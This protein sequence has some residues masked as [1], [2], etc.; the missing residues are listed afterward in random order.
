MFILILQLIAT[1]LSISVFPAIKGDC[2][3][4]SGSCLPSSTAPCY[5][6]SNVTKHFN[7]CIEVCNMLIFLNGTYFLNGTLLAS[8]HNSISIIGTSPHATSVVCLDSPSLFIA[9]NVTLLKIMNISWINCG[10]VYMTTPRSYTTILLQNVMSA[11]FSHVVF[12]NTQ[13]YA[14]FGVD[15]HIQLSLRNVIINHIS[16]RYTDG[17]KGIMLLNI[18]TSTSKVNHYQ[19]QKCF[20]LIINNCKFYNLYSNVN[21]TGIYVKDSSSLYHDAAAIGLI[22]HQ[23]TVVN[24]S[25]I[26]F[27]NIV[28]INTPVVSVSYLL[29]KPTF[30][31]IVNSLF[32][33]I[34]CIENSVVE[35][36]ISAK[37]QNLS[38]LH[39]FLFQD[40]T[41][42]HNNAISTDTAINTAAP[43]KVMIQFLRLLFVANTAIGTI[44]I[45]NT[46]RN[47]LNISVLIED[48]GFL[49]NDASD[50]RF[51]DIQLLTLKGRNTF[52]GN[53]AEVL[54]YLSYFASSIIQGS[55]TFSNN[56]VNVLFYLINKYLILD[57]NSLL[58]ITNNQI[59]IMND[60][61]H[62]SFYLIYIIPHVLSPDIC[63]FQILTCIENVTSLNTSIIFQN[64][65]GYR[66][67]IYGYPF[68]SCKWDYYCNHTNNILL[69][70]I[71]EIIIHDD[72]NN[73]NNTRRGDG[74]CYCET[75]MDLFTNCSKTKIDYAIYP[76]QTIR[77]PL[78]SITFNLPV[79]ITSYDKEGMSVCENVSYNICFPSPQLQIVYQTCT[80]LTYTIK[81]NSTDWCILCFKTIT[82]N[83]LQ[84]NVL[85]KFN[86]TLKECPLGSILYSGSCICD[87]ALKSAV[88]G[89]TCNPDGTLVRPPYTWISAIHVKHNITDVA[90]A[91]ECYMDYCSKSVSIYLDLNDPD[92]Q[93]LGN[94]SGK[95][96]GRCAKG[97]SAV[98]G[99]TRCKRCTNTWLL[100]IPVLAVAG[101]LLVWVLF[102]LNLTVKD[103]H[104]Y[105]YI[106]FVNSLSLYGSRIFPSNYLI[107]FPILMSDLDLGIE[108]CFYNGMTNYASTWLQFIFPVY[109]ILLV[110][111]VSFV[112]RYSE[113]FERLTRKRVIPVIATLYLLAYNKMMFITA[114]GLFAYRRL[115]YLRLQKTEIY[116]SLYTQIPLFGLQFS[117]L[118]AFCIVILLFLLLPTT[119]LLLFSKPLL[120]YKLVVKYFKPFLD[121]YQAPFK[122]T[123]YH[124]LGAE[125][126]MRVILYGCES[127]R[128]D[129]TAIAYATAVL[130]YLGYLSFLQPFKSS[131]N[132]LIY[133]TYIC[134]LGCIAIL[135]IYYPISKPKMYTVVFN[136]LVGVGFAMF[137]MIIL[138]HI[139]KYRMHEN[140]LCP[141]RFRKCKEV[142]HTAQ[143][144]LQEIAAVNYVQYREEL[145]A[146]DPNN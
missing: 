134:I 138:L 146:L 3:V 18:P 32:T 129:Y 81:S 41:F 16:S 29:H 72:H 110:V 80:N 40:C 86:I 127:L 74:I 78:M 130:F 5:D 51:E 137:L 76:G 24:I 36:K 91:T 118:F 125:L 115:H 2:Y 9:A 145:L 64:N 15:L 13:G 106:L 111:G 77:L 104:I 66:A 132:S 143:D 140:V 11:E 141:V 128:A 12:N 22:L 55:A 114:R 31:S 71:F 102:A 101:I 14:L 98:F 34:N 4:K 117:F 70:D 65:T 23:Q 123:C 103:G 28:T 21:N 8:N 144:E 133:T 87:P 47:I 113:V 82:Q 112:S 56:R 99:T 88:I 19:I 109:V 48:C 57:A 142:F 35:V 49:S 62:Q 124:F 68:N 37:S 108:V 53:Y 136:C 120:K 126:I 43:I 39:D 116:W 38:S 75:N 100:L 25:N 105:G 135:L 85:Y 27:A 59:K 89:L 92:A 131:L 67:A 7:H 52:D 79:S 61:T 63:P 97:F 122:D 17:S 58:N 139:Y 6:W 94:R 1:I 90:Y 45:K 121:A 73:N 46:N 30:I 50:L 84:N 83:Q 26:T 42:S 60:T 20:V 44:W 10:G 33:N 107:Y 93:C 96:C 95:M 69:P 54:I 119:I